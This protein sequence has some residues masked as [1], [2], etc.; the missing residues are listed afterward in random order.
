MSSTYIPSFRRRSASNEERSPLTIQDL[1]ARFNF[2][3]TPSQMPRV[4][5]PFSADKL[6]QKFKQSKQNAYLTSSD[7][8]SDPPPTSPRSFRSLSP[9]PFSSKKKPSMRLPDIQ[10]FDGSKPD[11][12][13]DWKLRMLNK[14][15]YNADHFTGTTDEDREDFKIAYIVSRLGEEASTQTL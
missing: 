6:H 13:L 9:R 14:L 8:A 2:N 4:Q 7:P 15:R 3:S 12:F 1:H 11:V 5:R 10:I